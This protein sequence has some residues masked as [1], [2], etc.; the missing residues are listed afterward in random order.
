[1]ELILMPIVR[2]TFSL[3]FPV[4]HILSS[5]MQLFIFLNAVL[6]GRLFYLAPSWENNSQ[7]DLSTA[8]LFLTLVL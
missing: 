4:K 8:T 3:L 7:Q 5:C 6:S 2:A 1:M